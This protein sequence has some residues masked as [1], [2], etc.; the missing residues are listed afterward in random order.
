MER[1]KNPR[2][3][4]MAGQK[5]DAREGRGCRCRGNLLAHDGLWHARAALDRN[6]YGRVFA[7]LDR[8]TRACRRECRSGVIRK[9]RREWER[10]AIALWRYPGV[11]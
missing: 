4:D 2:S 7:E 10:I 9:L 11:S 3:F 1:H 6:D 8:A 5:S